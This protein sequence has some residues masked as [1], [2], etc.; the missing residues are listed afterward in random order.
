MKIF[1]PTYGGGH[2]NIVI[3]VAM[4]LEKLG[5]EVIILGLSTANF[6]L[7][8][9]RIKHKKLQDYLFLYDDSELKA[10]RKI[11][12][13]LAII[14]HNSDIIDFEDALYYY[15][16]GMYSLIL[17]KGEAGALNLFN[18]DGRKAF[19]PY[20]FFKRVLE[21]EKPDVVTSTCNVRYEKA[22]IERSNEIGIE[23]Y[24]FCDFLGSHYKGL[25]T[26]KN[27]F[28]INEFQS[29][30]LI[31]NGIKKKKIH[32]IGQ[33]AFDTLFK[34][35]KSKFAMVKEL[36]IVENNKIILWI[37]SEYPSIKGM[38]EIYMEIKKT[39]E[40]MKDHSF[41]IKVH[42]N[43]NANYFGSNDN[44]VVPVEI[45][46]L[47]PIVTS[48]STVELEYIIIFFPILGYLGF[49]PLSPPIVQP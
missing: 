34:I 21:Y 24:F 18:I 17:E 46:T 47:S 32:V 44:I 3:P 8:K 25:E 37:C 7:E 43:S 15:G 35:E 26:Y 31:E 2:V 11:G 33:P 6:T 49:V 30:M 9:K 5:A 12:N 42:P 38:L 13:E 20:D 14:H 45:T 19:I 27:I 41:I 36:N 40:N 28:C 23:T 1:M 16:I 39:A 48:P 29:N 22:A 4:E 10:I